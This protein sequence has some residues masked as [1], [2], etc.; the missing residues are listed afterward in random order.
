MAVDLS[1]QTPVLSTVHHPLGRPGGPGLFRVKDLQLPAYIQNIAAALERAGRTESQAIQLAIGACQRWARGG[2]K[3]SAEVR[4]A[5]AKALAEWEAAKARAH[6]EH[7]NDQEAVELAGAFN[8]ALHPRVPSGQTGGGRFG[9]AGTGTAKSGAAAK[10][11]APAKQPA[12][13]SAKARAAAK[14]AAELKANRAK[15]AQ[16]HAQANTDR[17]KAK[18]L[19]QQIS[20]INKQ[21]K[22]NEAAAAKAAKAA[23]TKAR[24]AGTAAGKTVAKKAP[25][26]NAKKKSAAKKKVTTAQLKTKRA[27]L[28]TQATSLMSRAKALDAQASHLKLA[29]DGEAVE[30]AM[31]TKTAR[32]RGPGDVSCKRTGPGEVTVTHK[33]TGM[34]IGTLKPAQHG[35]WAGTHAT[36]KPSPASGSMA[37]ALSGLIGVHNKIGAAAASA[38]PVGAVHAMAARE[39]ALELAGTPAATSGDGPRVT[40][41]A[42]SKPAK[43]TVPSEVQAVYKKLLAKGMKPTQ[44]MALAKRAAAMHGK[45][46]GSAPAAKAA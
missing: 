46:Q 2:G 1:A 39:A 3:V 24:A 23:K 36:G 40:A 33:P 12:K 4:A 14:S 29:N 44:A 41:V 13:G 10:P 21:I 30:L 27:N 42:G 6:I 28:R 31:M 25:A 26:K 18:A 7:A 19:L 16:L 34:K 5:A 37:G 43:T 11:K 8:S 9:S 15:A 17:A 38:E 45:A 35:G 32:V 20:G 22:A